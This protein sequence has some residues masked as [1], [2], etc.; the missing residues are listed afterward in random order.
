MAHKLSPV[1]CILHP[2]TVGPK[3]GNQPNKTCKDS[4]VVRIFNYTCDTDN[5]PTVEVS[6]FKD[7]KIGDT[8]IAE[9]VFID[10]TLSLKWYNFLIDKGYKD[11]SKVCVFQPRVQVLDNWGWCTG[12]C[13]RE[14]T[15]ATPKG[16]ATKYDGCYNDF[17]Y[18]LSLPGA[19]DPQC[20]P[21]NK[22]VG[23]D[24]WKYFDNIIVVAPS[25]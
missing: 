2:V 10:D 25:K 18:D 17:S 14:Y 22:Q 19:I 11:T 4:P 5:G 21:D 15:G 8:D 1:I 3:F 20:E 9:G 13:V 7:K 6:D 24:Q 23:L 16:T 12:E